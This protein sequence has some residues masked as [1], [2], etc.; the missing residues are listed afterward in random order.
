[1]SKIF[2]KI[3]D[4]F[5]V[6]GNDFPQHDTHEIRR[7]VFSPDNSHSV[8]LVSLHNGTLLLTNESRVGFDLSISRENKVLAVVKYREQSSNLL[9]N[10]NWK[11]DQSGVH[12]REIHSN[13]DLVF[14]KHLNIDLQTRGVGRVDLKIDE[15]GFACCLFSEKDLL[16]VRLNGNHA[17]PRLMDLLKDSI[18]PDE[19]N[20]FLRANPRFNNGIGRVFFQNWVARHEWGLK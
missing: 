7:I 4:T 12:N 11:L 20:E 18:G 5:R 13:P 17:V 16:F 14:S 8:S 19:V 10:T 1:M 15:S 9:I 3:Y 2:V 6:T